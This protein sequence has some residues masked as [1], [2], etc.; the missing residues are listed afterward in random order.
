MIH[1]KTVRKMNQPLK[2]VK[3][4]ICRVKNLGGGDFEVLIPYWIPT[5][6]ITSTNDQKWYKLIVGFE[7]IDQGFISG[8]DIEASLRGIDIRNP[9]LPLRLMNPQITDYRRLNMGTLAPKKR[10][11]FVT[12]EQMNLIRDGIR[13]RRTTDYNRDFTVYY[14][15]I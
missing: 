12:E 15:S 14:K 5:Y 10:V 4:D 13:L 6:C 7:I 2:D 8:M 9:Y 11:E 1:T 3:L